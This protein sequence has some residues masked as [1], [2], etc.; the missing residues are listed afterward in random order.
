MNNR[1]YHDMLFATVG[2]GVSDWIDALN[3]ATRKNRCLMKIFD[4]L[5]TIK[6]VISINLIWPIKMLFM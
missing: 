1:E 4:T 5:D 6:R 3:T 2:K